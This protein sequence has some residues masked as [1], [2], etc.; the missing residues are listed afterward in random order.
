[1]GE[2]VCGHWDGALGRR[3]GATGQVRLYLSGWRCPQHTPARIAGRTEPAT[4]T[5][6]TIRRRNP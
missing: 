5:P 2:R 1:M 3:C 4:N 6:G